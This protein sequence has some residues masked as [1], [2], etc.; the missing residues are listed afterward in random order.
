M[1]AFCTA[2][3]TIFSNLTTMLRCLASH[4]SAS[5]SHPSLP[6]LQVRT[7]L[8]DLAKSRKTKTAK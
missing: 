3:L 5:P 6:P 4:S 2:F 8:S 1:S 7:Y